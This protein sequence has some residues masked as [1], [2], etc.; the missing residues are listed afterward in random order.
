MD[1][2]VTLRRQGDVIEDEYE[3]NA[4]CKEIKQG[5]EKKKRKKADNCFA[6]KLKEKKEASLQ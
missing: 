3:P 6:Y 5:Q 4:E 2:V 1:Y